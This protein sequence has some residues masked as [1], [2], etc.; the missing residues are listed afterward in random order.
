MIIPIYSTLGCSAYT[1]F[2]DSTVI[3]KVQFWTEYNLRDTNK[4]L[5]QKLY[6]ILCLDNSVIYIIKQDIRLYVPYSRPNGWTDWAEF[7]CGHLWVAGG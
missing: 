6:N 4:I 1:V 5:V 3:E 2:G 7:F